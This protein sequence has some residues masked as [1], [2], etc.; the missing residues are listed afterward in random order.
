M[1]I[2]VASL[3][4]LRFARVRVLALRFARD[5]FSVSV[6]RRVV[7]G[8]PVLALRSRARVFAS[9]SRRVVR[10]RSPPVV[11]LKRPG[12]EG[13]WSV[14]KKGFRKLRSETLSQIGN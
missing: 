11:P 7:M 10:E 8:L 3:L 6:S 2:R 12:R 13:G 9:V 14:G 5:A 4:A 1:P